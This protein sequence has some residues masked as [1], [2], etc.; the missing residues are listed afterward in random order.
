MDITLVPETKKETILA[1]SK[2]LR[3]NNCKIF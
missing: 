2:R 1:G 3:F